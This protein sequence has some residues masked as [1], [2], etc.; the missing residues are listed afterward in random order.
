MKEKVLDILKKSNNPMKVGEIV[1]DSGLDKKEVE[2]VM[3]QLKKENLIISPK[4]CFW[5]AK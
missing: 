2:K 1:K 4:R 3:N 5:K